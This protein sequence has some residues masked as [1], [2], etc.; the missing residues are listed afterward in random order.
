MSQIVVVTLFG[1]HIIQL[2]LEQAKAKI[3]RAI[4]IMD[5]IAD[6]EQKAAQLSSKNAELKKETKEEPKLGS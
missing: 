1:L 5:E 3:I 6:L 4:K 2:D